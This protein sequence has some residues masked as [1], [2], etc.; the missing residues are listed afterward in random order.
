MFL[1]YADES[2]DP[3]KVNSPT[4]FYILSALV[5]HDSKWH[6]MID[7]L[8]EFRKNLREKKGFKIRDEIHAVELVNG[9]NNLRKIARNDRIDIIKQ[10][11]KWIAGRD[12]INVITVCVDKPNC[13][14]DVF[15]TA[16]KRMIQRFDNTIAADNFPY[17]VPKNE[18]G[19]VLPDNTDGKKLTQLLRKMR[20]YNPVANN[21]NFESGYRDLT[22]K[23][24][25]EDPWLK[26]SEMSSINQMA[27]IV[28]Y[29]ARQYFEPNKYMKKMG[30]HKFYERLKP[31]INQHVCK[32]S[33]SFWIVLS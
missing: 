2:G 4:N 5:I 18:Y 13:A 6:Q 25:I 11:I 20:R 16:W 28:A 22:L 7:E 29:C 21:N 23:Y 32:N 26:D 17:G 15:E 27:D 10:C 14:G 8:L 30:G 3:G 12:Y 31:V 19:I 24:V 9:S 33:D 1:L